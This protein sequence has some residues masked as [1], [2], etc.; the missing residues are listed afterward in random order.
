MQSGRD[1]ARHALRKAL[2]TGGAGF[3]GYHLASHLVSSG[4]HVDLVDSFAR[5]TSDQALAKLRA[6]ERVRMLERDLRAS[7]ALGGVDDDYTHVFHLAAIVG[8]S[9][10]LDRPYDVLRDN[11][12]MLVQALDSAGA[13]SRLERFVFASTSEVYA[14]TFGRLGAAIPTPEDVPLALP[15]LA[16]RRTSYLLSKIYGEAMCHHAGVPFTIV[17][18]HNVYG[19]R[20]GLSH[21]IP[22]LLERAHSANEA[23][24]LEVFSIDHRRTF[25]YVDDAVAIVAR[26]ALAEGAA[27]E[28]LNVGTEDGE[29]S[30]GELARLVVSVVGK[31]LEIVPGPDTPGSPPR[32]CPDM[33]KTARLTGYRASV[34]LE[35]GIRRTYEW[36]RRNVFDAAGVPVR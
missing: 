36:Y 26:A 35:T 18:P 23:G 28:T 29:V 21:V 13:Q 34:D 12:A 25:C 1:R 17:R 10:V 19:P 27:G 4:W 11:V 30:I 20:M 24:S 5:G 2:V 16:H 7:D 22:E 32:R 33:T 15:D 9:R 8:V 6:S 14:G 3:I 31:Q